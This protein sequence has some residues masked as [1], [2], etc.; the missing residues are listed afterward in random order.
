MIIEI[1]SILVSYITL[2]SCAVKCA[3]KIAKNNDIIKPEEVELLS[4]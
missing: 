3:T 4:S 2:S 1:I